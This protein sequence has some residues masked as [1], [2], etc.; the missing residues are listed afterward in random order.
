M[1]QPLVSVIVPAYNVERYV[2]TCLQSILDQSYQ[3]FEIIVVNDGSSDN[4][5]EVIQSFHDERISYYSQENMGVSKARNSGIT[6]AKGDFIALLDADDWWHEDKL[7]KQLKV[8]S[9]ASIDVSYTDQYLTDEDGRKFDSSKVNGV[10]GDI[11]DQI[12]S[13]NFVNTSSAIIRKSFLDKIWAKYD[14]SYPVCEDWF[15]WFFLAINGAK[16]HFLDERITPYRQH[17]ESLSKNFERMYNKSYQLLKYFEDYCIEKGYQDKLVFVNEGRFLQELKYAHRLAG[18]G[19][20]KDAY[21][22]FFMA[23]KLKPLSYRA[24]WGVLKNLVKY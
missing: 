23:M 1:N 18:Q 22:H 13:G 21:K 14:E 4:T 6:L 15:F 17:S 24:C 7:E 20:K 5:G 12:I 2:E 9:D 10:S 19:S 3:N 8:L 16:F 11:T